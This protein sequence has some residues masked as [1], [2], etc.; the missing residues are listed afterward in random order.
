[1]SPTEDYRR[2]LQARRDT[3]EQYKRLDRLIGNARLIVGLT[4]FLAIWLAAG[5][6]VVSGWWVF[7]PLVVFVVLVARTERVRASGRQAQR[8]VV[9]YERGLARIEDQWIGSGDPGRAYFDESHPYSTDLDIFGKGSLFELLCS[10][11]TRSG[12]QTLAGWL[13]GPAQP[14]EIVRRQEAV[15]ELRADVDLRED[16]AVLGEAVNAAIHPDWMKRWGRAPIVL[17]SPAARRIAPLLSGFI[18]A[19][20]VYYFAFFG[21][22]WFLI[23][24]VA[25]GGAF[26]IH[27]RNRVRE[28]T[29]AVADPAK[30]L[31]VFS[32][33]LARLEKENWKC[34][35]LQQ[36][37]RTLDADGRTASETIRSLV[38]RIEWLNSR[39]NPSFAVF[40][41]ILMW[42]T[43]FAFA[44]EAWRAEHGTAIGLWLDA[45]GELESLCCLAAYA[46]EHP[47]DPF[48]EILRSGTCFEGE[49]LRHPLLPNDRCIPNSVKLDDQLQLFIVSGSNMSGKSTLLRTIGVNVVLAF[50]GAPVRA[51]RMKVSILAIGAT[52][53]VMD[54][55]Q[56]GTSQFYA[57]IQRLRDI[58]E[59][60]KKMRVLF[61]LDEILHGT[62]SH[63]RAV[64]AEGVIRGLIDRGAIGIVT[65]H[66]LALA[67]LADALVPRAANFHFQDQLIDGRMVFDY[68][69]HPGVVQKSNALALMRAV[70]LEV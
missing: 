11:R 44:I 17:N 15:E 59:L 54:S 38:L 33:V 57:E 26:G 4:F 9:Y 56:A 60:T 42:A 65:T 34:H 5:P 45:A 31:D 46:Y 49:H 12:E 50:A 23:A 37:R 22:G 63:D 16:L 10:A 8:S 40:A 20:L 61:L 69:L 39:L 6:H 62:N 3:V 51:S 47:A 25:C 32:L 36:L 18:I 29:D 41:P 67:K 48:P 66:D 53:R 19:S 64:G 52:I 21:S 55:L 30:D 7:L 1:M 35:K 28:V 14:E 70:G 24:A 58:M 68:R 27:Y 43:Q 13:K 2:R